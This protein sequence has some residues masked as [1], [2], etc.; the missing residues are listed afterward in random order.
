MSER[1][2]A[3]TACPMG[4]LLLVLVPPPQVLKSKNAHIVS[5]KTFDQRTVGQSSS[6]QPMAW[7]LEDTQN[8]RVKAPGI[9]QAGFLARER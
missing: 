1:P 3:P 2:M 6:T 4:S 5:S 9:W 8:N 7:D